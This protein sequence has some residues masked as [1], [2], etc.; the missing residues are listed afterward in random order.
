MKSYEWPPLLKDMIEEFEIWQQ[1]PQEGGNKRVTAFQ[2]AQMMRRV[3]AP[4]NARSHSCLLE[5]ESSLE[6]F[7]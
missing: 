7:L 2:N 3:C 6:A 1:G 5:D 4:I